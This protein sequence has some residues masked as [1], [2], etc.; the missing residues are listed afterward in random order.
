MDRLKPFDC[1][2]A[3]RLTSGAECAEV[4]NPATGQAFCS[5]A[6]ADRAMVEEA[7]S[8]AVQAFEQWRSSQLSERRA[9]LDALADCV[10]READNLAHLLTL[11]QGKPISEAQQEVQFTAFMLRYSATLHSDR[12]ESLFDETHPDHRRIF[13]PLGVVAG[14]IPWNYPLVLAAMKIGPALLTGNAIIVKPAPTT[15]AAT[16]E[17]GRL[18][19]DRVPPGLIQILG[20]DGTVGPMLA[21][22]PDIRK[23]SFTGSTITGRAVMAA[24]APTLKRLTLELGGN[25][26]AIILDDAEPVAAAA[27]IY[28]GAFTN[29][30]QICGAVKRVY[31]HDAV[32]ERFCEALAGHVNSAVV[33]AGSLPDTTIGPVQNRIQYD[34]SMALLSAAEA[35]GRVIA[36]ANIPPGSSGFYVPPTLI[37]DLSDS[38]PLVREEQF[39]P[40]LPIMKF[41][42]DAD[43]VRRA[44]DSPYGLTASV[45][46]SDRARA[47][48]LATGIDTAVVHINTHNGSTNG[49][50]ASPA[51]QSGVG[52]LFGH[53]GFKEYM[54]PHLIMC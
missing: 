27:G 17:L 50:G 30:G 26:A 21:E 24:A 23:L 19:A 3:G 34:K 37:A 54:Q 38:H 28:S 51:K 36:R 49:Q 7:M 9:L 12:T 1:L 10:D 5:Y 16:L 4:V 42:N 41:N 35:A 6:T 44:N 11:E 22:H 8:A 20:D 39:A 32:Y 48:A 47:A 52:W 25:D 43:A 13:T 40:L 15:P 33:G 46:S 31:V 45:W 2:V 18:W 53:D 14:I 29:C